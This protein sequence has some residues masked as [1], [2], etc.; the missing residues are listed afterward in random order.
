LDIEVDQEANL[1]PLQSQV[2]QHLRL[3]NGHDLLQGFD[4]HVYRSLYEQIQF[5]LAIEQVL[6]INDRYSLLSYELDIPQRQ[7]PAQRSFV[8]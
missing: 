8:H 6:F 2:R 5:E 7:F 1:Q 4:L 3:V